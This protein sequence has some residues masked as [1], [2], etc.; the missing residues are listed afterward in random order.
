MF[1]VPNILFDLDGTLSDPAEGIINSVRYALE[2]V[3]FPCPPPEELARHIGPPLHIWLA[4]MFGS[5]SEEKVQTAMRLYRKRYNED[6]KGMVENVLYPAIPAVLEALQAAGKRLFVATSKPRSISE[7]IIQHF[8]LE[9]YFCRVYGSELDSTRSDKGDL[10]AWLLAQEGLS[11][12]E[13]VMIGDRKHDIIG[14][15]R[16]KVQAIGACWGYGT[17]EEL[18]AAGATALAQ[19]P[20]DL[21]ELFLCKT[22]N[23]SKR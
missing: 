3:G 10:I 4:E 19:K 5:G 1:D 6:G 22:Q 21:L 2:R 7:K 18:I 11:P 17:A 23:I 12:D 13:T 20:G 9:Q 14:A 15:S 8:R 16:N